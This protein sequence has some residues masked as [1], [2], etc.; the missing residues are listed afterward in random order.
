MPSSTQ[1]TH[2]HL[3]HITKIFRKHGKEENWILTTNYDRHLL[4][5]WLRPPSL[6]VPTLPLK[7]EQSTNNNTHSWQIG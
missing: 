2:T 5:L 1:H 6:F 4:C 3:K 7:N